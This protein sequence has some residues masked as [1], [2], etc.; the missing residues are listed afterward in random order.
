MYTHHTK[1]TYMIPFVSLVSMKFEKQ[2]L[3]SNAGKAIID[4]LGDED[5]Y[6]YS[7]IH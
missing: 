4:P 5:D 3:N 2:F 1:K 7:F 6:D